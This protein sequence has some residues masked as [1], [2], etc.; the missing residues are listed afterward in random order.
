[1]LEM[2]PIDGTTQD[3]IALALGFV[4]AHEDVHTAIL[5]TRSP[6][7][8]LANIAAVG[9]ALPVAGE[10]IEELS[11]RFDAVGREWRAID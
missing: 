10:I 9:T 11:R 2:G 7:H 8:M 6:E 3:P 4:L 1:M 5:G